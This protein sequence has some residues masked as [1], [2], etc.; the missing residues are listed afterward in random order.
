MFDTCTA[1]VFGGAW[2][3]CS[4]D[5]QSIENILVS[6]DTSGVTGGT[7]GINAGTNA[8]FGTWTAPAITAFNSLVSKSWVILYNS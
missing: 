6:L 8:V 4:L 3:G 5:A 2:V 1:T 7:L